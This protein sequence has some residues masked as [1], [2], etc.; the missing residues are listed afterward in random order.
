MN[1]LS[2]SIREF[3]PASLPII[4]ID[5]DNSCIMKTLGEV[6]TFAYLIRDTLSPLFVFGQTEP[7]CT[8]L[9]LQVVPCAP[10]H[11][12]YLSIYIF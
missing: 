4:M 10:R 9:F 8:L 11:E 2:N 7:P 1:L 6:R 12:Q 3:S 5:K